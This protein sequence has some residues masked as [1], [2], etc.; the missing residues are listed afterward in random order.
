M[1]WSAT[2]L[3]PIAVLIKPIA[4]FFKPILWLGSRSQ[5]GREAAQ[6]AATIVG[7]GNAL[8]KDAQGSFALKGRTKRRQTPPP[9]PE[10]LT[11]IVLSSCVVCILCGSNLFHEIIWSE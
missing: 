3:K 1:S 7:E 9:D 5:S 6:R 11:A 8:G 2:F 10:E 4:F